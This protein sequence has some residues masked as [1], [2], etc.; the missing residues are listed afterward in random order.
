MFLA[1]C[2]SNG[3]KDRAGQIA[4]QPVVFAPAGVAV[5]A[6]SGVEVSI[7]AKAA[8]DEGIAHTIEKGKCQGYTKGLNRSGY[9]VAFLKGQPDSAGYPALPVACGDY[10]G[11][12]WDKGGYI[13]VAGQVSTVGGVQT[14]ILPEH[15]DNF[16]NLARVSDY[17]AEH[18]MLR[19]NDPDEYER[20][21]VHG[22]G[23][24]HPIIPECNHRSYYDPETDAEPVRRATFPK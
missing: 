18:I 22:S 7:Q 23:Q 15:R 20:T 3:L 11:T 14:I 9:A 24:G 5:R 2:E 1:A 4:S 19:L 21:K 6:E 10:C 16:E 17:E 12:Y 13:L 8:I